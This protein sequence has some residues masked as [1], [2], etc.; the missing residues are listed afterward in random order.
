MLPLE[1]TTR[2]VGAGVSGTLKSSE[3]FSMLLP[4]STE[5]L[6]VPVLAFGP[7]NCPEVCTSILA[8]NEWTVTKKATT[9]KADRTRLS[10]FMT[11]LLEN[12]L[13]FTVP[14]SARDDHPDRG[15]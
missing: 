11:F 5:W 6:T 8:A 1:S 9:A 4:F 10:C 7:W 12:W 15:P 13:R 14:R 2:Q 3:T